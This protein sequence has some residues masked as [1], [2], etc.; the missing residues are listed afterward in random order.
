MH[1]VSP[2][3]LPQPIKQGRHVPF[4][5]IP[6]LPVLQNLS[7]FPASLGCSLVLSATLPVYQVILHS[8]IPA[9]SVH[10][11]AVNVVLL[12]QTVPNAL[13]ITGC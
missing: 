11:H 8:T 12:P 10:L 7:V 4:V 3:V 5:S 2:H 1:L 9:N 13:I 6:V